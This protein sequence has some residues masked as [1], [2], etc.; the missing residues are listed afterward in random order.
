MQL[1]LKTEVDDQFAGLSAQTFAGRSMRVLP[2]DSVDD[3][4]ESL[5]DVALNQTRETASVRL[6]G[7]M[8]TRSRTYNQAF[9]RRQFG[10]VMSVEVDRFEDE[11]EE[12]GK[13]FAIMRE[14]GGFGKSNKYITFYV[15]FHFRE[16]RDVARRAFGSNCLNCGDG[17]HFFRECP[18]KF[19]NRAA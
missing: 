15:S 17:G 14:K 13:V 12:F 6:A 2:F 8:S 5:E 3:L 18:A 16:E 10:A 7:G 9:R 19:S 11:V 4:M 1:A